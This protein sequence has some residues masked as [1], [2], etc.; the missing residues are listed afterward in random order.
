MTI[1]A[2]AAT[3]PD[4]IAF[5]KGDKFF[6]RVPDEADKPLDWNGDP[7]MMEAALMTK[8][9]F[10]PI[11]DAAGKTGVEMSDDQYPLIEPAKSAEGYDVF[12]VLAVV[13]FT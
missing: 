3:G 9:G 13:P 2:I 6:V 7:Y 10:D 8:W 1:R 11:V 4:R 5:Q 12:R